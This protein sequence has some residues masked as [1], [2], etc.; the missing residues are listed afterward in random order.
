MT[1]SR[2]IEALYDRLLTAWNERDAHA[3]GDCFAETGS[4]VGFDGSEVAT[5]AAIVDHLAGIF[6]D[7]RPATYVWK[8]REVRELVPTVVLLRAVVG[9]VPPGGGDLNP[10]VNAI[11]S[12]VA[13][14]G[15]DGWRIA[16]LQSTPA[17]FHGRPEAQAAL[18]AELRALLG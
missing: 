18:A 3:W 9:M 4:L 6:A 17:A 8:V 12:M 1:L 16:H 13:V 5:R 7:H 15:P 11:Q 14:S 2:D 10:Y